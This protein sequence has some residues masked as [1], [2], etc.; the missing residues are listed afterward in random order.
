M[1]D[2]LDPIVLAYARR[3]QAALDQLALEPPVKDARNIARSQ[4]R[5]AAEALDLEA[6]ARL[7]A[8][9]LGQ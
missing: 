3:V 4:A 8:T 7:A 2:D 9:L 6:C 5:T 1:V